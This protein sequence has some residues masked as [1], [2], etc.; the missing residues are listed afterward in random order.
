M[1]IKGLGHVALKVSDLAR[2]L[3]FYGHGLGLKEAFRLNQP[4]GT[5]WIVYLHVAGESFL[6]LLPTPATKE[7]GAL[8]TATARQP[9]STPPAAAAPGGLMHLCLLVDNLQQTLRELD[10]RGVHP[11]GLPTRGQDG[12]WQAW[13]SDPDGNRIEL[14]EINP[15][16]RQARAA[17]EAR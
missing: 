10:Q 6:E 15:A 11:E 1:M 14:M 2:A 13:L 9:V 5:P 16:S 3:E 8:D 7:S 4:D 17:H 12:N